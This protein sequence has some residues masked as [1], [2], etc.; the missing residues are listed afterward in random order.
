MAA[1]RQTCP[2]A[3]LVDDAS[4][5][6]RPNGRGKSFASFGSDAGPRCFNE[7]AA[8]WPRKASRRS[9]VPNWIPTLQ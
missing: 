7:A 3:G 2:D 6:P 8:K 4:M 1:E 5:R 9:P